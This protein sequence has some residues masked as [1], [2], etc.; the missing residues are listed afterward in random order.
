MKPENP[1]RLWVTCASDGVA[2]ETRG[3]DNKRDADAYRDG[4]HSHRNAHAFTPVAE[5]VRADIAAAKEAALVARVE[6][7]RSELQNIFDE[8]DSSEHSIVRVES[9]AALA[10]RALT[11]DD[12]LSGKGVG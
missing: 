9:M 5:Y 4:L 10:D 3:Y 1:E 6:K 8:S 7:L 2:I 11:E 12:A